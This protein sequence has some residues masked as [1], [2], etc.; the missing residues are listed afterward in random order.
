MKEAGDY[1][2]KWGSA[3]RW[4]RFP[5]LWVLTVSQMAV[6]PA[7]NIPQFLIFPLPVDCL[8]LKVKPTIKDFAFKLRTRVTPAVPWTIL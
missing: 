4:R 2:K 6:I 1:Q 8:I 3:V 7:I 5:R